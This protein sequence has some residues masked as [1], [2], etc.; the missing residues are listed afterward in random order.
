[1]PKKTPKQTEQQQINKRTKRNPNQL[2]KSQLH[3]QQYHD[4]INVPGLIIDKNNIQ[5]GRNK[6]R[7]KND[8]INK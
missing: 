4:Y 1:M 8:S 6:E 3:Y 7:K 5:K 2:T